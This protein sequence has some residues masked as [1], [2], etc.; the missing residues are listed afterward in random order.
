MSKVNRTKRRGEICLCFA[1]PAGL[2]L[3][4]LWGAAGLLNKQY[5]PNA[6]PTPPVW[7]KFDK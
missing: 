1:L 6:P 5:A 4:L 7:L 2:I 3:L